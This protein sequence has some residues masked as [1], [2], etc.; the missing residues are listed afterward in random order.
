ML[1]DNAQIVAATLPYRSYSRHCLSVT[2]RFS[3]EWIYDLD[4]LTIYHAS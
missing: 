3:L 2:V 4:K 1:R